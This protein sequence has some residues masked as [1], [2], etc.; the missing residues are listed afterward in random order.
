MAILLSFCQVTDQIIPHENQIRD[1]VTFDL[2]TIFE[3]DCG[4]REPSKKI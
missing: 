2:D 1:W 3:L 4:V